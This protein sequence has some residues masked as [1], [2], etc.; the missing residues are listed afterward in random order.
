MEIRNYDHLSATDVFGVQSVVWKI[1]LQLGNDTVVA[2]TLSLFIQSLVTAKV[3]YEPRLQDH[4]V[5]WL[6][7]VSD[8]CHHSDMD[9]GF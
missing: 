7:A 4:L 8:Q 3:E 5:R 6:S 2:D 9:T 1:G